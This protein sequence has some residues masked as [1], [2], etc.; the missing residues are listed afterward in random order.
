VSGKYWST[1]EFN[2]N[3]FQIKQLEEMSDEVTAV[4]SFI[5]N[6]DRAMGLFNLPASEYKDIHEV[7]LLIL[8][9]ELDKHQNIELEDLI[10]KAK[11]SLEDKNVTTYI[12]YLNFYDEEF[13]TQLFEVFNSHHLF[14]RPILLDITSCPHPVL[15][16]IGEIFISHMNKAVTLAYLVPKSY[17][18]DLIREIEKQELPGE[19]RRYGLVRRNDDV[20]ALIAGFESE[21]AKRIVE[22]IQPEYGY[23]LNDIFTSDLEQASI[24]KEKMKLHHEIIKLEHFKQFH[25]PRYDLHR[26][27]NSCQLIHSFHPDKNIIF[28][29]FGSKIQRVGVSLFVSSE[30]DLALIDIVPQE[31]SFK[32]ISS[33]LKDMLFYQLK[34]NLNSE[35]EN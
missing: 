33:G 14:D 18:I 11:S 29:C 32:R 4:V 13:A 7:H 21:K 27:M 10:S 12:H 28:A 25:L 6:E 9:E 34:R 16:P 22:E 8:N 3:S 1:S 15:M 2:F 23:L 24:A 31:L 19:I 30:P 17:D 20:L 5:N 26:I 35:G